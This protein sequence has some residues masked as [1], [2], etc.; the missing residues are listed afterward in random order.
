MLIKSNHKCIKLSDK[1]GGINTSLPITLLEILLIVVLDPFLRI[2]LG[3]FNND[4]KYRLV[5]KTDPTINP[6]VT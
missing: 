5:P 4:L 2:Y 3:S 6:E 1:E